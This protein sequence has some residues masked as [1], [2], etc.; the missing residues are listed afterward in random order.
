MA[1]FRVIALTAGHARYPYLG[2]RTLRYRTGAPP[3]RMQGV[4]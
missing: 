1:R 4:A 2:C 3:Q